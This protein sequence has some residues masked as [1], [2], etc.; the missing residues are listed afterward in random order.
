MRDGYT[1][2]VEKFRDTYAELEPL[3][4]QHYAEMIAS[5]GEEAAS[6]GPYNPRLEQYYVAC[7]GGWLINFVVRCE[8]VACGYANIYL[9]NDMHNRDLI[10]REDTLFISA[11]HRNGIGRTLTKATLAELQKRGVKRFCAT[12]RID[13]RVVKLWKRLGF[14]ECAT[15]MLYLF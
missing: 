14:R 8:G 5:M 3:Y 9:T 1:I 12:A 10:A 13:P 4:R 2:T 6:F 11:A 7:D 15:E